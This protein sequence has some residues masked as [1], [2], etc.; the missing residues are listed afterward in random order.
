VH[1]IESGFFFGHHKI[2][3][4]GTPPLTLNQLRQGTAKGALL[5]TQD[6]L[7]TMTKKVYQEIKAMQVPNF[8][9]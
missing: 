2:P 3:A 7:K 1:G 6:V 8:K 4:S 5:G 9:L